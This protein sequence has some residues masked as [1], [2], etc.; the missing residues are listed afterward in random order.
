[1]NGLLLGDTCR[2]NRLS[3]TRRPDK[4][5]R[6]HRFVVLLAGI[7]SHGILVDDMPVADKMFQGTRLN[8]VD[9]VKRL[10]SAMEISKSWFAIS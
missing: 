5:G 3:N 10:F 1:M 2:R 7:Q 8:V 4:E 9:F 6:G